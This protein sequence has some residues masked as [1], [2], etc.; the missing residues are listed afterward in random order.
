MTIKQTFQNVG[1]F[2]KV[3]NDVIPHLKKMIKAMGDDKLKE[4][5]STEENMK[6]FAQDLYQKMP[7]HVKMKCSYEVFLNVIIANRTK[8]MKKKS[9]QKKVYGKVLKKENVETEKD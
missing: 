8:M 3:A 9:N 6:V 2:V 1:D 4:A 5:L 7:T